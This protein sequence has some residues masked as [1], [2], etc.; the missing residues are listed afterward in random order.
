MGLSGQQS[1]SAC[2]I[3]SATTWPTRGARHVER[4]GQDERRRGDPE[5]AVE[6][7]GY[8]ERVELA[9]EGFGGLLVPAPR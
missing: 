4:A 9:L 6:G 7:L 1:N 8:R 3:C 5:E 2:G